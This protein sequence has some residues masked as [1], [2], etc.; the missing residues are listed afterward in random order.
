MSVHIRRAT[1]ADQAILVEYN[2]CMAWETERKSLDDR[3]LSD[4]VAAALADSSK[5]WHLGAEIA[6]E[7]V[8]QLMIT[9]EWSD[10]R[11]GWFWW[12]QSVYVRDGNR[13]QGV[14]QALFQETERLAR[15][16]GDVVGIRLYVERENLIAQR[17][18]EQL[19]MGDAGYLVFDKPLASR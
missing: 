7:V 12:I 5:G 17:T 16:A 3:A 19:G 13:R 18:Y 14:F 1:T 9:R 2:R 10:W 15:E 11:N 4:G 8:G 6:G